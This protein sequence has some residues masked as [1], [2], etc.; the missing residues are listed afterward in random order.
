MKQFKRF[1]VVTALSSSM[2]FQTAALAAEDYVPLRES[3]QKAGAA[4]VWDGPN[5]SAAF[6][7]PN[8]STGSVTV[9]R[10]EYTLGSRTGKLSAA[11]KLENGVTQ[12]PADFVKLLLGDTSGSDVLDLARQAE[13]KLV[14][15]TAETETDAVESGSDAADDPAIWVNPKAPSKSTL[16]AT[17]KGGGV[18][19]YN[20]DGKELYSYKVGKVNN[21]DVRY[22][23][24][25][26]GKKVDIAA[27]TNR[28]GNTVEFFAIDPETG[29]LTSVNGEKIRSKMTEVYGFS[30]YHSLKTGKFY[31]LI[32]GKEGEFE[33]YEIF[34]NGSG[35]INGRLVREFQLGTIAEGLVA[36]DEYGYMYFSEENVA[37]WKFDAEPESGV[38]PIGRVDVPD[39][40]RLTA[41]IEGL[42]LYYGK[43]GKGYLIASSQGSNRYVIYK[44]EGGNSYVGSFRIADGDLTDGTTETDGIDVLSFG[45][46]DKYPGGIFVAQDDENITGGKT[47]N[48][49]FKIV[50]WESIAKAI[51]PGLAQDPSVDPRKLIKRNR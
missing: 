33:Q 50:R 3:L 9:G 44:R 37:L 1:V 30:L 22:D 17:N 15:V 31:A 4:V 35:K 25:L 7:L 10:G 32:L 49:N 28:S 48:Q 40:S 46:G 39:G 23:F 42:A 8:G 27:A 18:L 6:K 26:G 12:V 45:L 47:L 5:K 16:I 21:I 14:Q 13:E 34:D 20:L 29:E 38:L 2:L 41:D 51:D 24:P 19:V 36:D 43:D 11:A